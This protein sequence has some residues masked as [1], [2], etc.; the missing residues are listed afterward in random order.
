MLETISADS[1]DHR[2][3]GFGRTAFERYDVLRIDIGLSRL[4]VLWSGHGI[5]FSK[6]LHYGDC[7]P[8]S[9]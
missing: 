3:S 8:A 4:R 5:A 7:V 1:D 6:G 2:C 9:L